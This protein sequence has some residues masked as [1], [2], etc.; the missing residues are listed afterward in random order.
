MWKK[1]I[2]TEENWTI[3]F[4]INII[5]D[6]VVLGGWIRFKDKLEVFKDDYFK[7][8]NATISMPMHNKITYTFKMQEKEFKKVL[9]KLRKD[10][11]I[12]QEVQAHGRLMR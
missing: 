5:S 8:E 3:G 12:I 7:R 6:K 10:N 1:Y 4:K 2:I 9:K 11:F